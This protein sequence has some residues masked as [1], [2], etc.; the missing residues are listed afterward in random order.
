MVVF[1]GICAVIVFVIV[2]LC[3]CV[4]VCGFVCVSGCV[5]VLV[6]VCWLR[7]GGEHYQPLGS[8]LFGR[9]G[10]REGRGGAQGGGHE[11]T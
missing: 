9:R 7:S 4:Y 2:C 11:L 8:R 1:V 10:G 3:V 5:F 6:V